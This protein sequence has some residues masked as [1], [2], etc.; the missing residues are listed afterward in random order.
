MVV[1]DLHVHR[2]LS[3]LQAY[4]IYWVA[5]HCH[6]GICTTVSW[7]SAPRLSIFQ[8]VSFYFVLLLLFEA[9]SHRYLLPTAVSH[10]VWHLVLLLPS[11]QIPEFLHLTYNA[12]TSNQTGGASLFI[13]LKGVL[14]SCLMLHHRFSKGCTSCSCLFC[15][16]A[17]QFVLLR[18]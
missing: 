12:S 8:E 4:H 16:S 6:L 13:V 7:C 2:S 18:C 3:I 10:V 5:W 14:C 15:C 17:T 1:V 9:K 11:M